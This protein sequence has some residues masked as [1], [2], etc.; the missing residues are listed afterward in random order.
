MP[1]FNKT[2]VFGVKPHVCGVKAD[3]SGAGVRF[4]LAAD[5]EPL[6]QRAITLFVLALHVIEKLAA[7]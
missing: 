1:P 5:A 7:L 4:V 2:P 6:D 3:A